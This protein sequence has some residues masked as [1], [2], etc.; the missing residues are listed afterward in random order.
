MAT[1]ILKCADCKEEFPFT[2]GEQSFYA[3]KG[4]D[5]P[6]RCKP[7]RDR[8]KEQREKESD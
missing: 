6:K 1:K 2:E 5:A 7:C 3:G 4:F 8:R